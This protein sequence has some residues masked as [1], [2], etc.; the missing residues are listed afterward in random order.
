MERLKK[1]L[2]SNLSSERSSSTL[3]RSSSRE[4]LENLEKEL[5]PDGTNVELTSPSSARIDDNAI[6][7]NFGVGDVL[8]RALKLDDEECESVARDAN[9]ATKKRR[10]GRKKS[11]FDIFS[12]RNKDLEKDLGTTDEPKPKQLGCVWKVQDRHSYTDIIYRRRSSNYSTNNT[13][14]QEDIRGK[15]NRQNHR[16]SL[17]SSISSL[18]SSLR[19]SDVLNLPKEYNIEAKERKLDEGEND[20]LPPG[21][22]KNNNTPHGAKNQCNDNSDDSF[23]TLAS[24][25]EQ[26][27]TRYTFNGR[28]SSRI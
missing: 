15:K 13:C 2:A 6:T 24:I 17:R 18:C 26:V 19:G 27:R 5:S 25:E 8:K 7:A 28:A 1:S 4:W 10:G 22:E 21:D 14:N 20:E 23:S 16:N 3:S 12:N 9:D 11:S